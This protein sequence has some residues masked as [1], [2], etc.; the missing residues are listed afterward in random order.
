M[1]YDSEIFERNFNSE[2]GDL[3]LIMWQPE[4]HVVVMASI[5]QQK[6]G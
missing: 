4:R 2:E 3:N 5:A 6:S 1:Y